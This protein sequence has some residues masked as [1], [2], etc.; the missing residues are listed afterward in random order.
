MGGPASQAAS[1]AQVAAWK[2]RMGFTNEQAAEALGVGLRT[3]YR[4]LRGGAPGPRWQ[5]DRFRQEG[6]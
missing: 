3:F 1:A 4:W 5:G 6:K 2:K